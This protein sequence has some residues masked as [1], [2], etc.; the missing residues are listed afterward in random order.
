MFLR[1]KIAKQ[2]PYYCLVE[3]QRLPETPTPRQTTKHYLGNY[4]SA[5]TT[6]PTLDGITPDERQKFAARIDE[7][8]A[9]AKVKGQGKPKR[10][11]GRPRKA[12]AHQSERTITPGGTP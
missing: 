9:A 3:S 12:S 5:I 1:A 11:R 7:L 10:G 2:I 8:E 6:L 4:E